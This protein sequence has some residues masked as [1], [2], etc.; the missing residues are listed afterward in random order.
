M[1]TK[2]QWETYFEGFQAAHIIRAYE[3]NKELEGSNFTNLLQIT[4]KAIVTDRESFEKYLWDNG[5]LK[6]LQIREF[7]GE[8]VK[9]K[10]GK[11]KKSK[12]CTNSTY[13]SNKSIIGQ[14]YE[15]GVEFKE[16]RGAWKGKTQ[17]EKE[18]KE[19][20]DDTNAKSGYDKVAG[21]LATFQK[22]YAKYAGELSADNLVGINS[23]LKST[24]SQ[25]EERLELNEVA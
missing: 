17:L 14:C 1:I 25:I 4:A 7:N 13:S 10:G 2:E 20:K 11:Y 15:Y 3:I 18:L 9:T 24:S 8:D 5:E 16:N 19:L 12:V 6:V 23:V 21:A 22:V